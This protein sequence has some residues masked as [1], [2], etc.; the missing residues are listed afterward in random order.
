V[1]YFKTMK[2]KKN[3][4][5]T[6]LSLV[7]VGQM[8]CRVAGGHPAESTLQMRVSWDWRSGIIELSN[9]LCMHEQVVKYKYGYNVTGAAFGCRS[10]RCEK[11]STVCAVFLI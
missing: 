1:T 3:V 7:S 11:N 4:C 10:S 2:E 5:A 9:V 6:S 8:Q